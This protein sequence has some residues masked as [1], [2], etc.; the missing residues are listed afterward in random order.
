MSCCLNLRSM[1]SCG[2]KGC[3]A[4]RAV[5]P[6]YRNHLHHACSE[7]HLPFLDSPTW[8]TTESSLNHIVHGE[9]TV[10]L[11]DF[12][13]NA[14]EVDFCSPPKPMSSLCNTPRM[15]GNPHKLGYPPVLQCFSCCPPVRLPK[16]GFVE[17]TRRE[18]HHWHVD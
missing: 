11:I 3:G 2:G 17:N 16:D 5:D 7:S 6:C 15:T 8:L 4:P 18:D 10:P 13:T 9:V 14:P 1:W 12:P